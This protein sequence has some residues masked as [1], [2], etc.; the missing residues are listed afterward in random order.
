MVEDVLVQV[1]E[2]VFPA[3]F[4]VLNMEDKTSSNPTPI[5]LGRP[6]LK[7]A[8]VMINVHDGVLIMEFD[9]VV[10]KFNIFEAMKYLNDRRDE[11][12]TPSDEF[13]YEGK[14]TKT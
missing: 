5:L 6:F 13:H 11:L 9:G 7:I 4:Y 10:I 12:E 8:R 2:L 3:D 14:K 1:N